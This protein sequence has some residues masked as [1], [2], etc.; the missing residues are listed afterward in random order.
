MDARH[1][2]SLTRVLS[3]SDSRRRVLA[4]L[5]AL[6]VLGG[7]LALGAEDA[8]AAGRRKRRVKKHKH[9]SGRRRANRRGKDKQ[10]PTCTPESLAQACAGQCG[11]V[12]NNCGQDVDCGSCVCDPACAVCQ[13]CDARTGQCIADPAQ[14]GDACGGIGQVCQAD[15]TCSCDETSCPVCRSCHRS[16]ECTNPCASAGCCD[17][18]T[19]QPGTE[20]GACGSGGVTCDICTGQEQCL[21]NEDNEYVCECVPDCA[22]KACGDDGCGGQCGTCSG[23]LTACS[24]GQCTCPAGSQACGGFCVPDSCE[25][26][27]LQG[28]GC[29]CPA[30]GA[31]C[32]PGAVCAPAPVYCAGVPGWQYCEAQGTNRRYVPPCPAG[33]TLSQSTCLC[34]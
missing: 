21:E 13:T 9:G 7:V 6:P 25:G 4:A 32:I 2:D 5:A 8:A 23:A 24:A 34:S 31:G 19:C 30:T 3:G 27:S 29:Y 14:N 20:D 28:C 18:V 10:P 33:Q 22:G 15:G 16:G 17:G 11:S 26:G 1:F 12:T